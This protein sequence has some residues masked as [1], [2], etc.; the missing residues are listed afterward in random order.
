MQ[1]RQ[2][3]IAT[4]LLEHRRRPELVGTI[5]SLLPSLESRERVSFPKFLSDH[6]RTH[7]EQPSTGVCA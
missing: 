6:R 1:G 4:Q 5:E 7:V 2:W 3:E